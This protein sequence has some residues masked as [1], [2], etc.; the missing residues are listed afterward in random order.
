MVCIKWLLNSC[1]I[2]LVLF[3]NIY[4]L[5]SFFLVYVMW[6]RFGH[7][8]RLFYIFTTWRSF[9]AFVILCS[10]RAQGN[11]A[12]ASWQHTNSFS[13]VNTVSDSELFNQTHHTCSLYG[14]LW[15]YATLQA[16]NDPGKW[17][18]IHKGKILKIWLQKMDL[19]VECW[20]T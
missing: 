20:T 3:S 18:F 19:Y 4:V 13:H 11:L 1:N 16:V 8:A 2:I 10:E 12:V 14:V 7:N 17:K 5:D 6:T 9:I 15:C